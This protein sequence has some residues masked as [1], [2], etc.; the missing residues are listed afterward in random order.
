MNHVVFHLHHFILF[1]FSIIPP[2]SLH[3]LSHSRTHILWLFCPIHKCILFQMC[4]FQCGLKWH[5]SL[6]LFQAYSC[7]LSLS[8]LPLSVEYLLYCS[9]F[10]CPTPFSPFLPSQTYVLPTPFCISS[11]SPVSFPC[12]AALLLWWLIWLP[13][14]KDS[15]LRFGARITK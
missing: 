7:Y 15:N 3:V 9:P 11:L 1:T 8:S 10:L 14:I 6:W 13:Q 4:S 12:L 2:I 5:A